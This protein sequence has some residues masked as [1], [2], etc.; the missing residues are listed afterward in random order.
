MAETF[1]MNETPA[2]PEVLNSDEKD[3]LAVAESIEAAEQEEQPLLAGKFKDSQ[4]LEQAYVELQKKLGNQAEKEESDEPEEQSPTQSLLDQLYE[5]SRGDKFDEDT[6][7]EIAKADPAE[8][9]KLYLQYRNEAESDVEPGMTQE[10]A[11][12]LKNAVG[13]DEQYNEMLGWAS[14]NLTNQEID[15]YDEIMDR[16]DPSAAYWAVQALSYR[17]RDANGSEGELVQGKP[18]SRSSNTF[19]SQAEVVQAMSDPRYDKDPAYRRDVMTR[20]ENS[21]VEF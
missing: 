5:Q 16:G 1:T 21:D 11:D 4:A 19:R 14:K 9:A 17:Y 20:L 2:D 8:L 13:G 18:P 6:L 12:N 3:S 15:A 7:K 10:F